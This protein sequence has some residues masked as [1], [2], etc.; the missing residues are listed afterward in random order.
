MNTTENT[1]EKQP[2]RE[3]PIPNN[4]PFVKGDSR[5]N[6]NGRPK[7]LPE[8]DKL[9]VDALTDETGDKSQ[10]ELI[11]KTLINQSLSGDT[12]A[13]EI[14][15]NRAYG[16]VT[17]KIEMKSEIVNPNSLGIDKER[18]AELIEQGYTPKEILENL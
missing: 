13:S 10:I 3:N 15:L 17:D 18:L 8:L 11:L 6:R 9:L 7:Q 2:V 5:I 1:T 16:K 4:K 14:L 12:R